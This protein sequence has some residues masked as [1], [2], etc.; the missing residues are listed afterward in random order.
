MFSSRVSLEPQY[1]QRNAFDCSCTSVVGPGR[2]A[3]AVRSPPRAASRGR[4]RDAVGRPRVVLDHRHLGLAAERGHRLLER[5]RSLERGTA[6]EGRRE[7]DAHMVAVDLHSRITPRSTSEITG[8]SG[9]GISSSAAQTVGRGH[10]VAPGSERRT[11]VISFQSSRERGRVGRRVHE[12]VTS[13]RPTRRAS[14]GR[15]SGSTHAERVRPQL[16]DGVLKPRV[17]VQPCRPT[18]RRACGGR[19]PRGRFSLRGPRL[20]VVGAFSASMRTRSASS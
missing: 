15:S 5:A 13:S 1:G 8:I 20:G 7:L 17:V 11:S 3:P 16:L 18:S 10:H 6:E 12:L 9:S 19:P 2:A 4:R 14:S